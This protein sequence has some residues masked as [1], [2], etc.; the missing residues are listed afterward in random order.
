MQKSVGA[1][2]LAARAIGYILKSKWD[3]HEWVSVKD[4]GMWNEAS[5]VSTPYD[6]VLA[7]LKLS[8]NNMLRF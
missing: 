1:M 2:A 7:S 3:F 5:V 6:N 4:T 8:Y